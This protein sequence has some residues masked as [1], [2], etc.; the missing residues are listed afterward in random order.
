MCIR[1]FTIWYGSPLAPQHASP[2]PTPA[3]GIGNAAAS[4]HVTFKACTAIRRTSAPTNQSS[5]GTRPVLISGPGQRPTQSIAV[6]P[7]MHTFPEPGPSEEPRHAHS[8][9]CTC[10]TRHASASCTSGGRWKRHRGGLKKTAPHRTAIY[11]PPSSSPGRR[12]C[13]RPFARRL[14]SSPCLGTPAGSR[15]RPPCCGGCRSSPPLGTQ[16]RGS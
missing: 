5:Y 16:A 13:S 2:Y 3:R 8:R 10:C 1:P 12:A 7:P 15:P 9:C 6:S 11:P 14:R 4:P